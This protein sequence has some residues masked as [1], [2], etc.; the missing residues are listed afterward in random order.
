MDVVKQTGKDYHL[1]VIDNY[2]ELDANK[3]TRTRY[4]DPLDGTHPN[5]NGRKR[6]ADRLSGMLESII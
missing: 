2:Y 3:F 6:V 5:S 1:P 4:F